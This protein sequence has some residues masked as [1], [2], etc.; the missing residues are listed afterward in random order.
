[1]FDIYIDILIY[2]FIFVLILDI[3]KE[4]N[5]Y[6][7]KI[8]YVSMGNDKNNWILGY[9]YNG[10]CVGTQF[11]H[12]MYL[13]LDGI[14]NSKKFINFVEVGNNNTYFISHEEGFRWYINDDFDELISNSKLKFNCISLY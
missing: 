1:M 3:S 13:F 7:G 12:N 14:N 2:C 9:G 10:Y 5:R 8:K 6:N 11:P 4:V